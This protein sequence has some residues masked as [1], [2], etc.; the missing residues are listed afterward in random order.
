MIASK[1]KISIITVSLNEAQS[2][3][4]TIDSVVQ[5]DYI[6]KEFI[7]IDGGSRDESLEIIK[8]NKSHIKKFVSEPD[9]GIYYAMNKGVDL[10]TG[11]YTIFMNSGDLFYESNTISKVF[12]N[13]TNKDVIYGN[14]LWKF[15]GNNRLIKASNLANLRYELPF[16]HQSVFVKTSLIKK[17]KFN[18]AYKFIADFEFFNKLYKANNS[19]Q[20]FDL[21]I[22]ECD[23]HGVSN[24]YQ[25]KSIIDKERA[26]II[27]EFSNFLFITKTMLKRKIK[28]VLKLNEL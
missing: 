9:N 6:N 12:S 26:L 14:T 10:A 1:L 17:F 20:Y 28:R 19:F 5:Q 15:Y 16:N 24:N 4:I 21:P 18:T 3:K 22:S 27:G 7:I 23:G 8:S 13:T 25:N 2:L 11:D